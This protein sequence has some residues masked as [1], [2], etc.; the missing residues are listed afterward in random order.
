MG[1]IWQEKRRP[2]MEQKSIREQKREARAE[3]RARLAG[4][5]PEDLSLIHISPR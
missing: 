2:R 4:C 1:W 5:T 3:A